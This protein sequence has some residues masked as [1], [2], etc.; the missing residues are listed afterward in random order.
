[1]YGQTFPDHI[2]YSLKK[3]YFCQGYDIC[4]NTCFWR[5]LEIPMYG[6][7]F[8]DHI[9]YSLKK[10]YFCQGYDICGNKSDK[11]LTVETNMD[12]LKN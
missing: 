12:D 7:T 9:H 10:F 11:N 4:S 5:F 2:H 6:Q 8:P 1:M 3:F